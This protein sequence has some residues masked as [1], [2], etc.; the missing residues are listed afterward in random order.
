MFV[1]LEGADGCGK[2]TLCV[3]LA[4]RM[5]ATAYATLPKK[6]L[7]M[8]KRVDKNVSAE[9]YYR[10]YRDGIYD[11]SDEIDAILQSGGKVVSDRISSPHT[12]ITK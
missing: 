8:R 2:T 4:E 6:Y 1:A 7:Q 3:V 9:E 5:G 10:F 11:A 12:H